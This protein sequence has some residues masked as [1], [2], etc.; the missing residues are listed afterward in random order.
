[1]LHSI[2]SKNHSVIT[3]SLKCYQNRV[4]VACSFGNNWILVILSG[5]YQM[6]PYLAQGQDL[7]TA[8]RVEVAPVEEEEVA[9]A[10][11]IFFLLT[12]LLHCLLIFLSK[13]RYLSRILLVYTTLN[14]PDNDTEIAITVQIHPE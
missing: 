12:C 9:V 8:S 10:N 2:I 1:M 3:K 5:C 4:L 7:E 14:Y 11:L 13:T 6:V